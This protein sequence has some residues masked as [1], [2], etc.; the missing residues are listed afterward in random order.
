MN[1]IKTFTLFILS[2][3]LLQAQSFYVLTGVDT[4]DPLIESPPELEI[5]KDDIREGMIDMSKELK[6]NTTGHPSRVL[7]FIISKF[8]VGETIGYKID[9]ELAEYMKRDG[10][11]EGVFAISY[12]DTRMFEASD[13]IEDILMDRVDDMLA[14]FAHQY[15]DDNKD[16]SFEK[17]GL[18]HENFAEYMGYETDYA[19]ALEK[20]KKAGKPL[21]IF[22]ST[23]Y[24]PWC[25][26][27]ENRMLSKVDI[28]KMIQKKYIPVMLNFSK[29]NFPK[30]LRKIAV[31]PALYVVDSKGE[32]VT[33]QFVGYNNRGDFLELLKSNK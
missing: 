22:M 12:M 31:V 7:A 4:Y 10:K 6:V 9:L 16:I 13:D 30:Q 14:R 21:F 27:I 17:V 29:K 5:Y 32:K 15:K 33:H 19:Q 23:T 2:T 8:S 3:M 18:T 25:R 11:K 28:D 26:K 20:G 24:C 1:F